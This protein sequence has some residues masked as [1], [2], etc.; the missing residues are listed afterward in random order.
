MTK[1]NFNLKLELHHRREKQ[2]Q[3]E[4]RL[5]S[6][7]KALEEAAEL[8]ELNDQLLAEL[9]KRDQAVEEAVGI[10]VGLE[11]KVDTL[12][13]EREV[14][15][16]FDANQPYDSGYFR[17]NHDDPPSSPPIMAIP[18]NQAL[19]RMP[20]F[21]SEQSEGAEAL[22]S[23]YLPHNQ[24]Y[25]E[26]ILPQL[27]EEAPSDGDINSPRLSIL[28]ES[29]FV[30]IYGQKDT[31]PEVEQ[32][33]KD[34]KP[35]RRHRTSSSVEKWVDERPIPAVSA[36]PAIVRS[37]LRKNHFLSISD[38]IESPLQK[39]EKLRHTL[40]R[41]QQ[42]AA[43][44]RLHLERSAS[45]QQP[46]KTRDSLRRVI[47]DKESFDNQQKLPP[48]PD[49]I[50]TSTLRHYQNSN[51]TLGQDA[52]DTAY[53]RSTSNFSNLP[54]ASFNAYQSTISIRPRSAGETITSRREG[55]GWDT[56]T[57]D[58]FSSNASTFSAEQFNYPKR[59]ETPDLFSF[60]NFKPSADDRNVDWGRDM[61]FNNAEPRLP[62]RSTTSR[63]E[64][65][66]RPTDSE[67]LRSDD[68]V[69]QTVNY[70][71][72]FGINSLDTSPRPDPPNRRS[73]L[74]NA[75]KFGKSNPSSGSG[76]SGQATAGNSPLST[77]KK[78]LTGRLFGRSET[79]PA[80]GA[81]P[82]PDLRSP[83]TTRVIL[84][85]QGGQDDDRATPPPIKRT[86]GSNMPA[87]RPRS[88]GGLDDDR[89]NAHGHHL[90]RTSAFGDGAE[91]AADSGTQ[92]A[93][94]G[95]KSGG[96]KWLGFGRSN[97]LRRT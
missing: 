60:S 27:L 88:A 85:S 87:Y 42:N 62:T 72:Q 93:G 49:T 5:E 28:S 51:D 24:S 70:N 50:S 54:L 86:R 90:R 76:S 8:R 95:D 7:E 96:R 48:T 6:F 66:R 9:E 79:S 3:L 84:G 18:H 33:E 40:E 35:Q 77:K 31:P 26:T 83:T 39:L 64:T 68:T 11:D 63:L 74:S 43:S 92:E 78:G 16:N 89:S 20:S 52:N 37:D 36:T 17:G 67:H 53:L 30:S 38:V 21:L 45:T 34:E 69:R 2:T 15:K 46:R 82:Q 29:S 44:A 13:R 65:L 22:R 58:D 71:A 91:D 97:S 12:M 59:T 94:E 47:T 41:N 73:S 4:A 25:T 75:L 14:V 57:Q 10:I 23:L 19:T 61:M 1:Q 80:L 56:E 55:H 81:F 32:E